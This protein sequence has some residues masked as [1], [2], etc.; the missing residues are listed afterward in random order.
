MI[1]PCCR[2]LDLPEDRVGDIVVIGG[3]HT[4]LGKREEDHDL[5]AV[6]RLRSHGGLEETTVPLFVNRRLRPSHSRQLTRGTLRNYDLFDVL[7]NGIDHEA[8]E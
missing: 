6:E 3:R 8:M 4:V 5:S 2:A 7:L 1:M